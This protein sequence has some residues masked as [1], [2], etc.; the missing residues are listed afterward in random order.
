M[1]APAIL[2]LL[3]LIVLFAVFG[4]QVFGWILA[5]ILLLLVLAIAAVAAG[6]WA[7][8]RRM[9]RRLQEL[10]VAVEAR[11]REEEASRRAEQARTGAIDVEGTVVRRPRDGADQPED[12]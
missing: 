9:R 11:L 6:L 12:P 2:V 7:I 10:G 5:F 3:G 4:I 1:R 8:K